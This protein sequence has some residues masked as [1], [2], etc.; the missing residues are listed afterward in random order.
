[1]PLDSAAGSGRQEPVRARGRMTF[2]AG[3]LARILLAPDLPRA[4]FPRIGGAPASAP[5]G[6]SGQQSGAGSVRRSDRS[7]GNVQ[8][9]R[10]PPAAWSAWLVSRAYEVSAGAHPETCSAIRAVVPLRRREQ[11]GQPERR[12]AASLPHRQCRRGRTR[13]AHWPDPALAGDRL[14]AP[15]GNSKAGRLFS[16]IWV[17][18][19]L[20]GLSLRSPVSGAGWWRLVSSAHRAVT[21]TLTVAATDQAGRPPLRANRS[22][23]APAAMS[24]S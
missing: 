1:M 7:R 17:H 8:P 6:A 9:P 4:R 23:T 14:V 12:S 18:S 15:A 2:Q 19:G 21:T 10:P 20:E 3:P 24:F 16:T 5:L 13:R 11:C 22:R